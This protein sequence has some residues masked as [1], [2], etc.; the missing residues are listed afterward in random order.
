MEL[1]PLANFAPERA[2]NTGAIRRDTLQRL[3]ATWIEFSNAARRDVS[4]GPIAALAS[5]RRPLPS[6]AGCHECAPTDDPT[7][8][9]AGGDDDRT[10]RLERAD[11][12]WSTG[13]APWDPVRSL[14]RC[15]LLFEAGFLTEAGAAP[16]PAVGGVAMAL[17]HRRILASALG[18]MRGKLTYRPVVFE[19]L[20]PVFTLS[21]LQHVVES[22]VGVTLHKQN[23]R[24]L[25]SIL[26]RCVIGQSTL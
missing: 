7:W 17:D 11:L 9:D 18:R 4:A 12:C 25:A 15:E 20:S 8:C 5:D 21:A 10:A 26:R 22:L 16:E 13:G 1:R 6:S 3:L 14:E 23:F 19:L 2:W 24:R